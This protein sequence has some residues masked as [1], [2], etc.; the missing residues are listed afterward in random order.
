MS[1][2]IGTNKAENDF[3]YYSLKAD[4]EPERH[5]SLCNDGYPWF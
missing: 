5:V 1:T 3:H 4:L 2:E